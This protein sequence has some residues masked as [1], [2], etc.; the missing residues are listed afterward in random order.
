[1]LNL[2]VNIIFG[3]GLETIYTGYCFNKIKDIKAKS[4]YIIFL[5]CYIIGAI[6]INF[7]FNNIN[8]LYIFIAFIFELIFSK[9]NKTK[10]NITNVFLMLNILLLTSIILKLA[11]G[12]CSSSCSFIQSINSFLVLG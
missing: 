7:T 9:L 8:Y 3:F 1:M 2:I 6:I 4:T 11:S 12:P 10:Y 5:I